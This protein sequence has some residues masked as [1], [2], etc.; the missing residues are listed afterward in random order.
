VAAASR[1]STRFLETQRVGKFG[2][3]RSVGSSFL[4]VYRPVE[5]TRRF[6]TLVS[7]WIDRTNRS[8]R[9]DDRT[10][11]TMSVQGRKE[12]ESYLKS[13][14][15]TGTSVHSIF[16][17]GR[18][19]SSDKCPGII[20]FR[21]TRFTFFPRSQYTGGVLVERHRCRPDID[22]AILWSSGEPWHVYAVMH[23]HERVPSTTPPPSPAIRPRAH[24]I[25]QAHLAKHL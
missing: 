5:E 7:S 21:H 9:P 20:F 25:V 8:N 24:K 3:E 23:N 11:A 14:R 22:Y 12:R 17:R 18:E 15:E 16:E 1:R 2:R 4:I 13:L 19:Y 6:S 10:G